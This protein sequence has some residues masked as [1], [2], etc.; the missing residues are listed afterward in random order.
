MTPSPRILTV[1]GARPQFIK[2]VA[3]TRE[4]ASRGWGQW[5][6]HA[7]QHPDDHMGTDFLTELGV[8]PPMPA[9]A[10]PRCL[11]PTVWPTC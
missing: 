11:G 10:H 6:V 8:P 2:S 7:G 4:L 3:L 5:L 9:C 1:V